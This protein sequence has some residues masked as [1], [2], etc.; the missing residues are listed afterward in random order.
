MLTNDAA[1]KAGEQHRGESWRGTPS[2]TIEMGDSLERE[3]EIEPKT[4][5]DTRTTRDLHFQN[6][7]AA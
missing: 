1:A 7:M 2:T 5:G 4:A 6:R 3:G